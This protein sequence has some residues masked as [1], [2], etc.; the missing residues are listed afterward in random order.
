MRKTIIGTLKITDI[1]T[2]NNF[3]KP[4]ETV[5]IKTLCERNV[6]G[7]NQKVLN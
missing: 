3:N 6:D 2:N 7:S 4:R 1:F 5:K